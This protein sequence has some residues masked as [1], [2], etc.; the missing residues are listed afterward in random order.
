M[1]AQTCPDS[2]SRRQ[3]I[4]AFG[5]ALGAATVAQTAALSSVCERKPTMIIDTHAHIFP[6][7]RPLWQKAGDKIKV[8]ALPGG[9]R[10]V[11][12]A[13]EPNPYP[14]PFQFLHP[15]FVRTDSTPEFLLEHMDKAGVDMAVLLQ[16]PTYGNWDDYIEDAC[17]TWPDR[18]IGKSQVNPK[19]KHALAG[20]E[21][22]LGELGFRGVKLHVPLLGIELNASYMA[23][24]FAKVLELGGV[25]TIDFG[26]PEE[27]YL[28]FGRR[29]PGGGQMRRLR[30]HLERFTDLK[31]ISA[32]LD[33]ACR[34]YT[35]ECIQ[36]AVDFPN[37]YLEAYFNPDSVK[38]AYDRIGASRMTFGTD[39]PTKLLHRSYPSCFE[40]IRKLAFLSEE[41]KEWILGK[42]AANIFNIPCP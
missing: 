16:G 4:G 41:D 24:Y 5:G 15:S 7:F 12:G 13:S 29:F 20:L 10:E 33:G 2:V 31:F 37:L 42:T 19:S 32:H 3:F 11:I 6:R 30:P 17:R 40:Y 22:T 9:V 26:G 1:S 35:D 23:P 14:N 39:Y 27:K 36:L 28:K 25:V 21:W 38:K 18:F 8:I 34:L